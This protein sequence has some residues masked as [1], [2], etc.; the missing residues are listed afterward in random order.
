MLALV[1]PAGEQTARRYKAR[2]ANTSMFVSDPATR[3][4]AA[5]ST[6]H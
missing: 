3:Y 1:V 5:T 4:R 6:V 2:G